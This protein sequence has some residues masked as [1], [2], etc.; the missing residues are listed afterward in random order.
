ME[1]GEF[2]RRSSASPE[3]DLDPFSAPLL[4]S[5]TGVADPFRGGKVSISRADRGRAGGVNIDWLALFRS[6]MPVYGGGIRLCGRR[7]DDECKAES[8]NELAVLGRR[9]ESIGVI[10]GDIGPLG[11]PCRHDRSR[12]AGSI[13]SPYSAATSFQK[14]PL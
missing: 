10:R 5:V 2:D 9:A 11:Y 14:A 6:G 7:S 3:A 8:G 12:A 1:D 4:A 13:A